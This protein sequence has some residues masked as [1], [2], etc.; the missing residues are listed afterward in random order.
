MLVRSLLAAVVL[1]LSAC[2]SVADSPGAQPAPPASQRAVDAQLNRDRP[3]GANLLSPGGGESVGPALAPAP[4]L[5]EGPRIP[6]PP[7]LPAPAA[8]AAPDQPPCAGAGSSSPKIPR[9]ACQ[10]S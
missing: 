1:A 9:P 5:P 8:S 3:P 7:R 10:P 6:Q 4:V 2:A